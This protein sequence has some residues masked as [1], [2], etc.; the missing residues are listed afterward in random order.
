MIQQSL[1][2]HRRKILMATDDS[3]GWQIIPGY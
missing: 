3:N 1:V 2:E